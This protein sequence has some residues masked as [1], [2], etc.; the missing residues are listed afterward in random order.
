MPSLELRSRNR[1]PTA[2]AYGGSIDMTR[3]RPATLR[4]LN[5][6]IRNRNRTSSR[7]NA[8]EVLVRLRYPAQGPEPAQ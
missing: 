1:C 6:G 2:E 4:L 7:T 5:A 3:C 8:P